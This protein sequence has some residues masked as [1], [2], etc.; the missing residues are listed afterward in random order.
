[1]NN[2]QDLDA[3]AR[4]MLTPAE[5]ADELAVSVSTVLGWLHHGELRG[6]IV[7]ANPKSLRPRFRIARS[8]LEAVIA[9]RTTATRPR[10][11]ARHRR[12]PAYKRIV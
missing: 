12:R 5:V 7:S 2:E 1:M 10:T 9:A 8:D 6:V 4:R 11:T 3:A